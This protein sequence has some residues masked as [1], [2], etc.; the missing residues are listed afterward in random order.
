ML[1][2]CSIQEI[3]AKFWSN[4]LMGIGNSGNEDKDRRIILKCILGN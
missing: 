2:A 1:S 4:N 3:Q